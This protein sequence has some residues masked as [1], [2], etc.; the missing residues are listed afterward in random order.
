MTIVWTLRALASI[1][2]GMGVTAPASPNNIHSTVQRFPG[3]LPRL[4]GTLVDFGWIGD[5]G[6]GITT[7]M[8]VYCP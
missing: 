2:G 8:V 7:T 4:C 3:R 5:T 1:L 6:V